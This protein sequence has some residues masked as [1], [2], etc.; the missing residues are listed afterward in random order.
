M[1]ARCGETLARILSRVAG[2]RRDSTSASIFMIAAR[3]Q[4]R[5][6]REFDFHRSFPY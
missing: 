4:A 5:S 2:Q 6:D 1:E 3:R